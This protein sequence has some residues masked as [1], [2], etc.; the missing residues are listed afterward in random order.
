MSQKYFT[1]NIV[2]LDGLSYLKTFNHSE[3]SFIEVWDN[4]E[5]D[6]P[7]KSKVLICGIDPYTEGQRNWY[8][9]L[10]TKEDLLK[11]LDRA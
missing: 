7:A 9:V 10:D 11:K 1:I 4:D 2:H 5:N 6:H 3:V 8:Y